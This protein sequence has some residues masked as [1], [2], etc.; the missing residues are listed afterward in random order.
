M[1]DAPVTDCQG[2]RLDAVCSA[3]ICGSQSVP[4]DSAC[5]SSIVKGCGPYVPVACTGAVSQAVGLV[6]PTSCT[7]DSQCVTPANH[8]YPTTPAGGHCVP[9]VNL[10]GS[11]QSNAQCLSGNCWDGSICCNTS[12]N[13]TTCDTCYSGTCSYYSDPLEND[14][15]AQA[16][17]VGSGQFSTSL[18]A[19]I[20]NASD[21]EDWYSFHATDANFPL[22]LL[23]HTCSGHLLVTLTV[24]AGVDYDLELYKG[25]CSSL[26]LVGASYNGVGVT[27]T[28][29]FKES[30]TLDDT[31]DYFIKVIRVSGFSCSQ[32]YGLSIDAHL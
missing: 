22:E 9:W 14:S 18:A 15:C 30:C 17:S 12:C 7:V 20:Q 24:P 13:N 8:C 27:D 23:T 5:N 4:D 21:T 2:H 26:V 1:C 28:V 29:D 10:G 16:H 6:C 11:C 19:T 32:P 3:G 25:S 31:G